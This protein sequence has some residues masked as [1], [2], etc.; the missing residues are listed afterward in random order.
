VCFRRRLATSARRCRASRV[1]QRSRAH[2]D[3]VI[4]QAWRRLGVRVLAFLPGSVP[5]HKT[6]HRPADIASWTARPR[7]TPNMSASRPLFAEVGSPAPDRWAIVQRTGL[8]SGL[9]VGAPPGQSP[10]RYGAGWGGLGLARLASSSGLGRYWAG[11]L[12]ASRSRSE[13]PIGKEAA[14]PRGASHFIP[15]A[16]SAGPSTARR[17]ET[18]ATARAQ[19]CPGAVSLLPGGSARPGATSRSTPLG[20]ELSVG[21]LPS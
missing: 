2:V 12:P 18:T 16:G 19:D 11:Y 1:P 5:G 13:R 20:C 7:R 17:R 15:H 9:S 10:P 21:R 3:P 6:G 14:R 4:P 8:R